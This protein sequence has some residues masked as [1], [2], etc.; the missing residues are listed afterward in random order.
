MSRD[1]SIQR[2]SY[3]LLQPFTIS[4]GTKTVAQVVTV[5]I[6]ENGKTGWGECVPYA[7]Y[8]ESLD[9]VCAQIE[10]FIPALEQGLSI[11]ELQVDMK[12]GAARN[13][14]DCALWDLRAKLENT[15]VARLFGI[16]PLHGVET[17]YTI[18][19]DTPNRMA[20]AA[21]A[22]SHHPI[23]KIKLGGDGDINRVRSIHSAAP[24]CKII[25]DANEAWTPDTLIP[26][27][28]ACADAGVTLVEQPLP[29]GEDAMLADVPHPVPICADESAHTSAGLEDLCG[30]YDVINIKLDKTGGLSEAMKMLEAARQRGFG[31]MVGC[32]VG[33]SL[34]MAPAILPAQKATFVDLDAPLLLAADRKFALHY[35]NS[36]IAPPASALWG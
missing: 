18:S 2:D 20:Q 36:V 12:P 16:A 1:V 7:R 8:D 22:A 35:S 19:L 30:L 33:S 5:A 21:H 25:V 26:N 6:R 31:T 3:P 10:S 15:S 24:H 4:R 27:M 29:A 28:L 14:I 9:S 11:D 17:A 32:M 23:L 34:S 13:A